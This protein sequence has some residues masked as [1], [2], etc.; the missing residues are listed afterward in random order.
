MPLQTFYSCP[1][2]LCKDAALPQA[3]RDSPCHKPSVIV[4]GEM[5]R[6]LDRLMAAHDKLEEARLM[7]EEAL[8]VC[9]KTLG[10]RHPST[11]VSLH[12]MGLLLQ[13]MNKLEEARPLL[14]E[15]LQACRETLGCRHPSTL[16]SINNLGLQLAYVLQQ[17]AQVIDR[18]QCARVAATQRLPA[19]LQVLLE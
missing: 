18:G 16:T 11:L 2:H 9:R 14:E 10:D 3:K 6:C 19:R 17:Q 1:W 15:D 5:D 12:N 7:H 13:D 8:Q 4:F